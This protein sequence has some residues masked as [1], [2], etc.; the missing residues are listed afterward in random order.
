MAMV[1]RNRLSL[2]FLTVAF[3]VVTSFGQSDSLHISLKG[4]KCCGKYGVMTLQVETLDTTFF[5]L[6]SSNLREGYHAEDI[7]F[8]SGMLYYFVLQ[9]DSTAQMSF[10]VHWFGLDEKRFRKKLMRNH[11]LQLPLGATFLLS[12]GEFSLYV[13]Y[14]SPRYRKC[15]RSNMVR[16]IVE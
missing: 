7:A 14:H 3:N 1:I 5:E 2:I 4:N 9:Q 6:H 11:L 10:N 12:P 8:N 16:F 15:I 13:V